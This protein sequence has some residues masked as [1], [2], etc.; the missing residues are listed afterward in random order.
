LNEPAQKMASKSLGFGVVG[1]VAIMIPF[2][3]LL[4]LPL[5]IMAVSKGLKALKLLRRLQQRCGK[6]RAIAGIILGFL[7][8]GFFATMVGF[9]IYY[10]AEYL[11]GN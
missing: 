11:Y 10:I 5:G 8:I 4:M 7:L 2:G 9:L 1:V 3:I 6:G